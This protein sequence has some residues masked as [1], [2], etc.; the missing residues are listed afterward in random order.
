M[1]ILY[2]ATD[3]IE[4]KK[5]P[6]KHFIHMCA[7]IS[8]SKLAPGRALIQVKFDPVYKENWTKSREWVFFCETTA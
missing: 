8:N 4:E 2:L 1:I 5:W 7:L 3:S 6:V